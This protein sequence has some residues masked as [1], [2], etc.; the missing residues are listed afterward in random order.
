MALTER[1]SE[2]FFLSLRE[3]QVGIESFV[4]LKSVMIALKGRSGNLGRVKP[5]T[6]REAKWADNCNLQLSRFTS[7]FKQNEEIRVITSSSFI[8]SSLSCHLYFSGVNKMGG[9]AGPPAFFGGG[10]L[11]FLFVCLFDCFKL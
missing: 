3:R 8:T 10:S 2:L 1:W 6:F 9:R 11:W 5:V 4:R 7:T